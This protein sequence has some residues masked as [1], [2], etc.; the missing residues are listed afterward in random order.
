LITERPARTVETDAER[1]SLGNTLRVIQDRDSRMQLA[2][3]EDG[4]CVLR[5]ERAFDDDG[6]KTLQGRWESVPTG[7]GIGDGPA[8]MIRIE[9]ADEGITD[10][11]LVPPDS[12]ESLGIVGGDDVF[13]LPPGPTSTFSREDVDPDA[14]PRAR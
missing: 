4:E 6:P 2:L 12:I 13:K 8:K 1:A 14:T 3:G 9:L 11:R 5:Y 10:A 7:S